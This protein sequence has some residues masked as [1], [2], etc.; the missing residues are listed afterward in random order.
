MQSVIR[1]ASLLTLAAA[2]AA[3][4]G[5]RRYTPANAEERTTLVVENQSFYEMNVYLIRGAQRIRLGTARGN[6]KTTLPIPQSYLFGPTPLRFLAD[7]IGS[8]R[9]P[10]SDEITVSPGDQVVLTIPPSEQFSGRSN[11]IWAQVRSPAR[12]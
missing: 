10:V 3:C 5:S 2:L 1:R 12:H 4:G 7:P 11:L 8:R 6:M 9:T